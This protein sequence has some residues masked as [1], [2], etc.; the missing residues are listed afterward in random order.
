MTRRSLR[1]MSGKRVRGAQGQ[2]LVEFALVVPLLLI[3]LLG[4]FEAGRYVVLL[5]SLN[6]ATREGARYAI[7]HGENVADCSGPLR[8]G[9]S[10]GPC[11]DPR[12]VKVMEAVA[13]AVPGLATMGQMFVHDPV[14]TNHDNFSPPTRGTASNGTN[15]RGDFVTVFVDYKYNTLIKSIF[16]IDIL[17]TIGISAESSLVINY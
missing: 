3:L 9:L 1:S 11:P 16:G 17:P 13:D 15:T 10:R 2:A 7:V 4:I 6:N 8:P 12:G 14:W 5:E